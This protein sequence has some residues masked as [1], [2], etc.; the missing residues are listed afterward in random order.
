MLG[1]QV[2]SSYVP[3]SQRITRW[4]IGFAKCLESEISYGLWEGWREHIATIKRKS[5]PRINNGDNHRGVGRRNTSRFELCKSVHEVSFR[6]EYNPIL[7]YRLAVLGESVRCRFP[8]KEMRRLR[9]RCVRVT[10]ERWTDEPQRFSRPISLAHHWT[11]TKMRDESSTLMYES[12]CRLLSSIREVRA[13][14]S[15]E[16]ICIQK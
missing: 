5:R 2:V 9:H 6:R 15:S 3:S 10:G 7:F 16:W 8:S 11:V 4:R 12:L 13:L 1:R 14:A